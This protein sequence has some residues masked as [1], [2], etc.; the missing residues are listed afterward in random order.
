MPRDA[1]G[2]AAIIVTHSEDVQKVLHPEGVTLR[3]CI[4]GKG[5]TPL[6][7]LA[8]LPFPESDR[9]IFFATEKFE[10]E[11]ARKW[12]TERGFQKGG[13]RAAAYWTAA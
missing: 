2:A 11:Q 9:H 1:C 7:A 6:S 10:V 8:S 5:E 3:W 13:S 4:R 12:L